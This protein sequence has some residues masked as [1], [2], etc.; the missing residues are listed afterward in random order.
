M[1]AQSV[2][3]PG[4][5]V[6]LHYTITLAGKDRV[7]DSTRDD[8]AVEITLGTGELHPGLE[9]CLLGLAVGERKQ[10]DLPC[11]QAFGPKDS[12]RVHVLAK[13]DFPESMSLEPGLVVAF[14]TPSGEELAGTIQDLVDDEV[15]VDFS[16][17]LAG[18]DLV[19]DVEI[20]A[21][22]ATP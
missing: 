17:P 20:L 3:V 18:H 15:I 1:S 5:K 13:S 8:E 14:T 10:F 6:R 11:E 4:A 22:L 9:Q 2:V 16:H 12:E 19:F 7:A 21:I